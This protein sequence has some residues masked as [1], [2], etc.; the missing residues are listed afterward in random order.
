[1]GIN[2]VVVVADNAG[3]DSSGVEF[4]FQPGG[5]YPSAAQM[6]LYVQNSPVPPLN[7]TII[8][9]LTGGTFGPPDR[10]VPAITDLQ[11]TYGTL[12]SDS[13]PPRIEPA[14]HWVRELRFSAAYIR[15]SWRIVD[16]TAQLQI[17]VTAG[18]RDNTPS[19]DEPDDPFV[20]YMY[21]QALCIWTRQPRSIRFVGRLRPSLNKG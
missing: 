14:E 15:N 16:G 19:G 2:S 17:E 8:E 20:A 9:R 21:V 12:S 10:V 11:L 4:A 3:I 5:R 13:Q 7:A 6:T 1:M 18:L